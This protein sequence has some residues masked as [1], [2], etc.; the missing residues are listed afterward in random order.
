M[1]FRVSGGPK[2]SKLVLLLSN[3]PRFPSFLRGMKVRNIHKKAEVAE[4]DMYSSTSEHVSNDF[5][6]KPQRVN[7]FFKMSVG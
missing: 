3:D 1:H 4:N 5:G 6:T 2:S 7:Y